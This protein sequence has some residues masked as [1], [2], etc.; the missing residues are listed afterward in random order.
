MG[1]VD[2]LVL[3]ATPDVLAKIA[4]IDKKARLSGQT[5]YDAYLALSEEDKKQIIVSIP[6]KNDF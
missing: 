5:F 2:K 4:E 6:K 3:S 1:M